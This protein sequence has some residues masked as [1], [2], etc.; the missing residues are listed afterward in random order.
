M[1][2]AHTKFSRGFTLMELMIVVVIIGVIASFAYPSY[3]DSVRRSN[4][5]D[6]NAALNVLAN[7]LER[8]FSLNGSYTTD[9]DQFSLQTYGDY[10]LS[11]GSKYHLSVAAGTTGSIASSYSITAVPAA[12]TSQEGD[13]NCL[14]FSIDSIGQRLPNPATSECW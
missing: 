5:G 8:Y 1:N 11:G 2:V 3:L 10:A 6:A 9:L 7:D 4:R 14:M 13:T 12:D